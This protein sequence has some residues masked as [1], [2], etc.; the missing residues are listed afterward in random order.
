[1]YKDQYI[2][3]SPKI[4]FQDST[5]MEIPHFSKV[6]QIHL[7]MKRSM[8]FKIQI[9]WFITGE[10]VQHGDNNSN[11]NNNNK[12]DGMKFQISKYNIGK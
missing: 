6:N 3:V 12:I 9:S 11:S 8:I 7:R 4:H 5:R 2:D 1:M 10:L